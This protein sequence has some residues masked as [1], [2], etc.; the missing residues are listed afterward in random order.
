MNRAA[1]KQLRDA[2]SYQQRMV[3][4]LESSKSH[5]QVAPM[6]QKALGRLEALEAVLAAERGSNIE[7]RLLG[8]F[9]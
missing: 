9:E 4:D 1:A 5:P 7:L 6:Y 2:V 3:A 8:G